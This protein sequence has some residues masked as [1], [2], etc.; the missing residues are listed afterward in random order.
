MAYRDEL[1]TIIGRKNNDG[2]ISLI[3]SG[4]GEAVT[5]INED[6]YPVGSA[7]SAR[8]EHPRG[9]VLTR[10]DAIKLGIEIES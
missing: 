7:L 9:I 2:T 8:Y 3:Y 6:V 4:D 10:E 1:D 5:R